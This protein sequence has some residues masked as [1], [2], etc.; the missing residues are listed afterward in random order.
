MTSWWGGWASP[1]LLNFSRKIYLSGPQQVPWGLIRPSTP[2]SLPTPDLKGTTSKG[3]EG[4]EDRV[5]RRGK[6]FFFIFKH[7]WV[8]KRSW[9]IFHGGPG[10]VLDFLSV[11]E[12]EP[13]MFQVGDVCRFCARQLR[14]VSY[15]NLFTHGSLVA[16]FLAR[17]PQS[18]NHLC[19]CVSVSASPSPI[20][21]SINQSINRRICKAHSGRRIESNLRHGQSPGGWGG[22]TLRVVREVRWVFSQRLKVSNVFDS[23]ITTTLL[24]YPNYLLS[25][26]SVF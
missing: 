9:K 11:K 8:P 22:Y 26:A 2:K 10:K 19:E 5:R 7:L 23:L 21:Q 1:Q 15:H 24:L 16:R 4:R 13:W 12:W 17:Q 18:L 20:N 25:H 3:R 14:R 6:G